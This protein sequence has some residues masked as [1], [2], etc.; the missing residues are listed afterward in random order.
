[1]DDNFL[2]LTAGDEAKVKVFALPVPPT[3]SRSTTHP[4]LDPK[5]SIPVAITQGKTASGLQT[6]RG[7]RILFSQSSFTSPND[8]YIISDLKALEGAILANEEALS[9]KIKLERLTNFSDAELKGKNLSE[10]EEFWFK[11][12]GEKDVHGWVIKPRSWTE[13]EKKKWPVLL[14]IHGGLIKFLIPLA[15]GLH[16]PTSR[17]SKCLGG[18]MVNTMEPK[19]WVKFVTFLVL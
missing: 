15:L 3:P 16:M 12:A 1:M 5:Y 17:P 6:L 19:W 10:G 9:I 2:Y 13:G 7:S 4:K 11:G 8:V 18:F 14:L